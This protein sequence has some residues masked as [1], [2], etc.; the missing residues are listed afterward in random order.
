MRCEEARQLFD[1]YLDGE[2]SKSLATEL[3]AHRVRCPACRRA[4]ALLEVSGQIIASDREPVTLDED[5]SGR[6]LACVEAPER[7]WPLRVRRTLFY[8]GPLAAAAVIAL[9]F[10]GV[11]DRG[12]GAQPH[13]VAGHKETREVPVYVPGEESTGD[14]GVNSPDE[15]A[16][17]E[18]ALEQWMKQAQQNSEAKRQSVESLHKALDLTIGQWLDILEEA[19][20]ASASE[21][22]FPGADTPLEVDG[23]ETDP[24]DIPVDPVD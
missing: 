16:A 7:R 18:Y 9:A 13:E 5:F 3:A 23:N 21:E 2:L 10:L 1:A 15:T 14:S 17:A 8:A 24:I 20:D 22:H 4:L 12:N 11:F 6:L 19:K